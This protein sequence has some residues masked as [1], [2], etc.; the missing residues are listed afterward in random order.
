MH[1]EGSRPARSA[2]LRARWKA[3]ACPLAVGQVNRVDQNAA[4]A[5]SAHARRRTRVDEL[6]LGVLPLPVLHGVATSRA[7]AERVGVRG[8]LRRFGWSGVRGE[9]PSP[10]S[11]LTMR[12]GLSPHARQGRPRAG[13]GRRD[14]LRGEIGE[15]VA[16][17]NSSHPSRASGVHRAFAAARVASRRLRPDMPAAPPRGGRGGATGRRGRRAASRSP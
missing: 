5:C 8:C 16:P 9:P 17:I 13:R 2:S 4:C 14:R 12:S 1:D 3:V 15:T 11:Q 10:G 7:R 6:M